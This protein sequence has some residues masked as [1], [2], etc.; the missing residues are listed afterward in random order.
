MEC[1]EFKKANRTE[2]RITDLTIE[3]VRSKET[4]KDYTDEE[5]EKLIAYLKVFCEIAYNIW[6]KLE[7]QTT[8]IDI[9][10]ETYNTKAA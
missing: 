6:A 9:T 3:E 4:Y 5:A 2:K 8:I 7:S 10:P 1:I